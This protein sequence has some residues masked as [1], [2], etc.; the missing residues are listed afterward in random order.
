MVVKKGGLGKGFNSLFIENSVDDITVGSTDKIKIIDIVANSQ[1]PRKYFDEEALAELSKSISEHGVL[2]PILVRPLSDGTYQIVAGERRWR[3]SRMAGLT[4]IPA[5]VREMTPEQ[6]MSFALI[7]NLQRED[8]DPIEEAEGIDQ[9]IKKFSLT[10]EQVSEKIGKS[11]S[12]VANALRLLRL[13]ENIKQMLK[14]NVLSSGHAKALLSLENEEDILLAAKITVEQSLSVRQT[15]ALV[16]K[17][18]SQKKLPQK[19]SAKRDIFYDEAQF[20]LSESLGRKVQITCV[21]DKG[22]LK[23][24]FFDKEDL[25]K[26][27]KAFE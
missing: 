24:E 27:I 25:K 11:R 8:L 23:I 20:A 13:P 19:Q 17:I 18:K 5:V 3:A 16:K 1:Q 26:L 22:T 12:A 9:L 15:E 4:E 14:E 10:Q 2:Q 21:K 7:E 6:A